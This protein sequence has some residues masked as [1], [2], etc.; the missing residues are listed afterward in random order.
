[1][2][3]TKTT[4]LRE[5][6]PAAFARSL[7]VHLIE[8]QALFVPTLEE[9]FT[10]VGLALSAVSSDVDLHRLLEAQPDVA[11]ALKEAGRGRTIR[12]SILL[13]PFGED[14]CEVCLPLG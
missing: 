11:T 1:M 14:F 12:R 5:T 9:V 2:P 13:T 4:S 6:R 8:A 10:D 7:S 3:A